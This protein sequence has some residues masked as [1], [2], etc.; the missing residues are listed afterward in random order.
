MTKL[1]TKLA[2]LFLAPTMLFTAGCDQVIDSI[3]SG[4]PPPCIIGY[5]AECEPPKPT[6]PITFDS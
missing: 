2:F 3:T 5:G 6:P 1:K 4:E